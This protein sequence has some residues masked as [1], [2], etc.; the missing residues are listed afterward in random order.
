MYNSFFG[1][2]SHPFNMTPDPACLYLTAQHREAFAGLAYTILNK[3]GFAVLTGDAGTGKTTLLAKVLAS[4]PGER[5]RTAII[6]HPTLSTDD[7][8][9][10]VMLDFGFKDVPASKAQR[11]SRLHSFLIDTYQ[12]GKT[13]TLVIDEAHKLST[14]VLEEIR[15]LGNFDY[16]DQKLLQ[17]LLVGQTEF[18]E[19]LARSDLR[20]LKQ[21]VAVRIRLERLQHSDIAAYIRY[22]WKKAGGAE[23]IPFSA[24]TVDEIEKASKGLPRVINAICDNALLL[25]FAEEST[26][27]SLKHIRQSAIDLQL[28]QAEPASRAAVAPSPVQTPAAQA[29]PP[30]STPPPT[31][32]TAPANVPPPA[33]APASAEPISIPMPATAKSD[34]LSIF[35][36]H[37][38]SP[39][40]IA[41]TVGQR[42]FLDRLTGRFRLG[43]L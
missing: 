26:A 43:S 32:E 38:P 14:N 20:Q 42:S 33:A 23:P 8:L 22:R 12:Q 25:A 24:D 36:G 9:E 17:I 41:G 18:D 30:L 5:V 13:A 7:F 29:P 35:N 3:R 11:L 21:R 1:L 37:V 40:R 39:I 28:I 2:K 34:T 27:V 15:L 10:L 19:V 16:V 31:R 6:F 4:L